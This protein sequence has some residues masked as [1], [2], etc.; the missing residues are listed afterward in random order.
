MY[1]PR[2][3]E[4]TPT[5]NRERDAASSDAPPPSAAA[6]PA[7]VPSAPSK[8]ERSGILDQLLSGAAED[9]LLLGEKA[10]PAADVYGLGVVLFQMLTG[11]FPFEAEDGRALL[12]ARLAIDPLRVN[13]LAPE[14][15]EA[16]SEVVRK[17]LARD[18]AARFTNG[19]AL[20]DA[21]ASTGLLASYRPRIAASA[22]TGDEAV[23][24]HTPAETVR[25]RRN[26]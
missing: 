4:P 7:V 5:Q 17:S 2:V 6:A 22:S 14:V 21:L 8:G 13:A 26:A 19:R 11:A 20:A 10:S 9:E 25:E 24:G 1:P 12:L 18:P 15:P 23:G 3:P 16:L